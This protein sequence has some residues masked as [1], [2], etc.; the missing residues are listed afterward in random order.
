MTFLAGRPPLRA[1]PDPKPVNLDGALRWTHFT[2]A[3]V[4][5]Q[6]ELRRIER[7]ARDEGLD[8]Y[9]DHVSDAIRSLRMAEMRARG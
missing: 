3:A 7:E 5:P 4:A 6:V 2:N 1:V 8:A 9:A